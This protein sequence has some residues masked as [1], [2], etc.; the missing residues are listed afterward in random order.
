MAVREAL[1][2]GLPVFASDVVARPPGITLFDLE[3]TAGG[4]D[5]L[6]AFLN[7]LPPAANRD[8]AKPGARADSGRID[9]AHIEFT[10]QLLG[11][12]ELK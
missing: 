10:Q 2:L 6:A 3:D 5:K 12:E 4:A 11:K 1:A 7:G 8:D 9:P